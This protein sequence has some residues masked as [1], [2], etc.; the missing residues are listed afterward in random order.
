MRWDP[1]VVSFTDIVNVTDGL[2]G[3]STSSSINVNASGGFLTVAWFETNITPTTLPNGTNLFSLQFDVIG[4]ACDETAVSISDDPLGI[5]IADADEN[6]V[7]AIVNNGGVTVPGENC[8]SSELSIIG[9]METALAGDQVCVQF[10]SQGFTNIAAA[11]FTLNFDPA[12]ISFDAIQ[13]IN[14]PGVTQGGN[15]GTTGAQNG[16]ITFVWFDQN[17]TGIDLPDGTVLFEMC[18]DAIGNGGQMSQISFGND[19]T[20]IEFS[21]ANANPLDFTST[22]GKVNLE[23]MIEGFALIGETD[24]AAGPGEIVC[25]E[26]QVN[27]FIDI[28]SMQFSMN[29][30]P[31][32]LKYDRA[33]NYNLPDFGSGNVAGPEAPSLDPGQAVVVWLDQNVSGVTVSNGTAIFE[34]CFEVV[35]KCDDNTSISFTSDP[36]EIEV[37][38]DAGEVLEVSSLSGAFSLVCGGCNPAVAATDN[39]SCPG[40]SDGSITLQTT[41]CAE[42]ITYQWSNGANTKDLMDLEAGTYSVTV[43]IDGGQEFVID[44]ITLTDPDE[45]S[46]SANIQDIQDGGDGA[47]DITV[48]GGTPPYTYLWSNGEISEDID[49]LDAGQYSV[50]V[51]DDNGCVFEAGPYT[52]RDGSAIL[53]T[54]TDVACFGEMTGAITLLDLNCGGDPYTF[55]W[56][57]GADTRD[58]SNLAAGSYT[59]TVTGN[60]GDSCEATFDVMG[61][62][63]PIEISA[64]TTNET[65]AGGNGAIDL[66]VT[67][68]TQPYDFLWS[69]GEMTQDISG[70]TAGTYTVS[71]TDALGCEVVEEYFIRG[72]EIFIDLII[73]DF[74][75]F[76]VSC[77]AEC[78]AQVIADVTNAV[79]DIDY[80]WSTGQSTPVIDDV[81][82]GPLTLT[83]TDELGQTAET[84][85]QII[86]PTALQVE[87]DIT[88][89]SEAGS[90]DGAAA[91]IVTGG[92]LPYQYDWSSGDNSSSISDQPS[93]ALVLVVSDENGCINIQQSEICIEGVECY[94]AI[95]VITPNGDG[96][97][98][99]FI[100]QCAFENDNRLTV[101]NRYGGKEFERDNYDN[102]WEGTDNSGN[103][104][105]D[106]GY[107]WV[108]EVFLSNGD[109]R[110][111]SGTV[112]IIRSLD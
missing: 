112:T 79:G 51:T 26:V 105:S 78:D 19:P 109:M 82:A 65:G 44:D 8:T 100:I 14:W 27:D 110:V 87:L 91:A 92:I 88:C 25:M 73:S 17:A 21:D 28:V 30:D 48:A 2:P 37:S 5:E 93:G 22:P 36:T 24:L 111:F 58:I 96:K 106:G 90:A 68:G 43:T 3:F 85:V 47:I 29:W 95:T 77:F 86:E 32:V 84:T 60:D 39:P 56:S 108:L 57:N 97:N 107:H 45:I 42:P 38:N 54:V 69:N 61:A 46:V 74:N 62:E 55:D 6:N 101:Y 94:E 23:G 41:G 1:Q 67:G 98:D 10:T 63:S 18:F 16:E 31:G 34:I 4:E 75:G 103:E 20:P 40:E 99:Q 71:V 12:V 53:G 76:N 13:N 72:K 15:F 70:L 49:G 89:A 64:D 102:S 66:T 80:Q 52:V 7:G 35:G 59:V 11:Q 104:L 9:S 33:Q 83:I 50:T 81:C